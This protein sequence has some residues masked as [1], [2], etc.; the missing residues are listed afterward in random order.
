MLKNYG[1]YKNR[2]LNPFSKNIE[3]GKLFNIVPTRAISD[4]F[5]T[6]V[7]N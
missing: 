3:D 2:N 6:N 1:L 5:L 4:V 7:N